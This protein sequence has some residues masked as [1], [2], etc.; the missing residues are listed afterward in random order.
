M[1]FD[2]QKTSLEGVLKINSRS[3]ADSRGYFRELY[4]STEFSSLPTFVQDNFS[5]SSKGVLRG[6]HYQ[7][8][9]SPQ[10]KLVSCLKGEIFDVAVDIRAGSPTFGK[11]IGEL[12]SEENCA[13]L[14]IPAGF[15]HGFQALSGEAMVTY[16][17]TS[18]YNPAAD[19]GIRFDDPDINI[20]WPLAEF[21]VS[22]KDQILPFLKEI[23]PE[24][25][26]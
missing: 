8:H 22:E 18:E 5:S 4:K 19:R 25:S 24:A 15:A 2:I 1:G 16:K 11:W 10:G 26:Q 3:F 21:V 12:L 6:L 13:S 9:P 14:W 23:E 7:T 17:C 20:V